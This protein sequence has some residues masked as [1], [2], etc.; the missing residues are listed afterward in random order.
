VGEAVTRNNEFDE[1]WYWYL[2]GKFRQ[3]LS[4]KQLSQ[5]RFEQRLYSVLP[6]SPRCMEC[7]VPFAGIGGFIVSLM[8]VGPSSLTPRLCNMCEKGALKEESGAEV[9]LS[10][11]FAD[12][13]GSTM[14]A[15]STSTQAFKEVI[16]RF[17]KTAADV[18]VRH[19]G[20][21]GR[22]IGDQVIGLFAP[23]FAG[24]RHAEVALKAAS[25]LLLATG[26]EPGSEPWI[27]IGVGVHT[28][29]VYVGAVGS[30]DGVNEIAVLGTGANLAARL[31][32]EAA[33]GEVLVSP[34]AVQAAGL[35]KG[36]GR[37]RSVK[38][39]GIKGALTVRVI[40]ST[41]TLEK[42]RQ[43]TRLRAS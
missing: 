4:P 20:M 43:P 28:G 8:G 23:R 7:H 5:L 39:K 24:D 37:S 14:L 17:Y 25:D 36:A 34:A 27:K 13:R 10:L 26:H 35:P 33:D 16:N 3:G 6:G 11:L 2:T 12:V 38:L 31:S 22:L 41:Y 30:K 9:E 32:S 42:V 19:D 18:L 29:D 21:V 40:R 15:E 1:I